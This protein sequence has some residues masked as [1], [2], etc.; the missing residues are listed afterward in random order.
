[1]K[2]LKELSGGLTKTKVTKLMP[3]FALPVFAL[4]WSSS[5]FIAAS[6]HSLLTASL[7]HSLFS[8]LSSLFVSSVFT[9]SPF[10]PSPQPTTYSSPSSCI[11]LSVA[12]FTLKTNHVPALCEK[13]KD[14]KI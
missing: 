10:C 11:V 8:L 7:F 12:L 5:L 2:A 1:M 4:P 13:C 14:M 9:F 6:T 3:R